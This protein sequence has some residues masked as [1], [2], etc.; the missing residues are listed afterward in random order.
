MRG[1]V[2]RMC[3][4]GKTVVNH[5]FFGRDAWH[6]VLPAS[7]EFNMSA[8]TIAVLALSMSMDAFVVSVGRG[9]AL[10]RPRYSEA[11]RTG[12]VFGIVEALTPV[13]GWTA[14]VAAS[15]LVESVDH[16]I[17]FALLGGVGLHMLLAAL[18][19]GADAPPPKSSFW[20]L[21]V[22]AIGTSLDAMA[23]GVSLALLDV[24]I[25]VIALAI[26]FTTFVMSSSGM[27]L[28]RLISDRWSRIAELAAGITLIAVGF[29]ILAEH[30]AQ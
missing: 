16:W 9:A 30:L 14:G 24:N 21:I 29:S 4:P 3:R 23:V 12:V 6:A 22:T 17:A 7:V 5:A 10:G 19:R 20:M 2:S 8:L 18:R 27:L 11:L 15:R 13:I 1:A 25:V 28:G 26:G